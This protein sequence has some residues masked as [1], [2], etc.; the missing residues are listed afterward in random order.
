MTASSSIESWVLAADRP[1]A[2]GMP[3]RST[4]RWYLLPGLPRSVGLGPVSS[5]PLGAHAHAVQAGPRPVK[6]ALPA[7]LV[8]QQVVELLPDTGALPVTQAPPAGD[9]AATAELAGGRPNGHRVE[10]GRS[11]VLVAQAVRAT[12]SSNTLTTW[13]PSDPANSAVPPTA[14]SP[15]MRPCLWAVVPR[16]R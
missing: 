5:P 15:A 14:V 13:V 12:A 3:R 7:E 6:L 16:G 10:A 4:S 1:T 2:R 11:G 9:R 8:E